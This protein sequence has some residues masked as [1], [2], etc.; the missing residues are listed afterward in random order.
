MSEDNFSLISGM[1]DILP[2]DQKY[3]SYLK[4]V[5]RH[6]AREAGYKRITTPML[7][8]FSLF[9]SALGKDSIILRDKM[10]HFTPE[11]KDF[12]IRFDNT[13]PVV[14]SYFENKMSEQSKLVQLYYM[15]PVIRMVNNEKKDLEQFYQFGLELFGEKDPALDAQL[16]HVI[17]L[18]MK[19]C[20][21]EKN[22]VVQL[23]TMGDKKDREKYK[24]SLLDYFI[25]KERSLT[26]K[27]QELLK[28]NPIGLLNTEDE[29]EKILVSLAPKI[30]DFISKDAMEYHEI[31][32]EYL[33]ELQVPYEENENLVGNL[34]YYDRTIFNFI[35]KDS[36]YVFGSG[37]HY[38]SLSE[39]LGGEPTPSIG[40]GMN[41]G[42][43][44]EEMKIK[45]IEIK[46]KDV[47]QVFVA[48]IGKKAKKKSLSILADIREIGIKAMGSMGKSSISSQMEYAQ[49]F[50]VDWCVL[51]GEQE[52]VDRRVILKDMRTG[53]QNHVSF[54]D[55]IPELI[56]SIKKENI[57][58][59]RPDDG[60]DRKV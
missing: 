27:S 30:R 21:V 29:D 55:L 9:E 25:G 49:R 3:W 11:N 53:S 15:D 51:I 44:V 45:N 17:Y 52:V 13:I 19:D 2:E 32:K 20:G 57:L 40:I 46:D 18:I 50:N 28:V 54:D 60:V 42:K 7:E 6:R 12:T 58:H 41:M 48:Q 36:G 35:D 4:K 31:V 59:Y 33:D 5:I 37:G 43:V 10:L 16:L 38:D 34:C 47:I 23:S 56:S 1:K 26:P 8:K 22:I 39:N 14:R 24:Q